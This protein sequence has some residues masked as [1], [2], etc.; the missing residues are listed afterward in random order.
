MDKKAR[1]EAMM[2]VVWIGDVACGQGGVCEVEA[3]GSG[4]VLSA[5]GLILT[6][7]HVVQDVE[8]DGAPLYAQLRVAVL[9]GFDQPP[10]TVCVADPHHAL[11]DRDLDLAIFKCELDADLQPLP[12]GALVFPTARMGDSTTVEP[13]DDVAV[14]GYPGVG[15]GTLTYMTGK[16]SGFTSD[17]DLENQGVEEPSSSK[18]DWIK[19]DAK[20]APGNSGGAAFD[21]D[22]TLIGIPS[23]TWTAPQ[24]GVQYTMGLIRPI[25]RARQILEAAG[26]YDPTTVTDDSDENWKTLGHGNG[27][28]AS[29][30]LLAAAAQGVAD[31]VQV[32]GRLVSSDARD[33]VDGAT[34]I[35]LKPGT[36]AADVTADNY[37]KYA[38]ASGPSDD[39]G[40]FA[41]DHQIAPG[42]YDLVILADGYHR[43]VRQDGVS[44]D[45][46]AT[47]LFDL[48]SITLQSAN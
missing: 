10:E 21:D 31:G 35:V 7:N 16:V 26:T 4:T 33:A 34:V 28:G 42:T 23:A 30:D 2:A 38:L 5:D 15:G 47:P 20:I 40:N 17:D 43:L 6:N 41:L 27:S 12:K 29:E 19:T 36:S 44:I 45:A 24:D 14:I 37:Q 48:G 11:R 25:E 46:G 9:R 18:R 39:A 8:S 3:S 32:V 1:Q 13:G 22:G